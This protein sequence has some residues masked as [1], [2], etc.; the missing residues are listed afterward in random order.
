VI[1]GA[2]SA[3]HARALLAFENPEA[4]AQRSIAEGLTVRDLEH[5]AQR[6]DSSGEG[7]APLRKQGNKDPNVADL[8]RELSDLL[9]ISVSIDAKGEAGRVSIRYSS[10]EQLDHLL[11]KLRN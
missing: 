5:L 1:D 8:E 6:D 4:M 9:G 3:G 10:L 7:P 2:I 11:L